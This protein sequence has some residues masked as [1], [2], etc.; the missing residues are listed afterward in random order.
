MGK[1]EKRERTRERK[2]KGKV[3]MILNY[4]ALIKCD[5]VNRQ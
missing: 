3:D 4:D 2:E 5:L 1:R